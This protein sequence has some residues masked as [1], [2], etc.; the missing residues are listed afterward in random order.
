MRIT[1]ETH[2]GLLGFCQE[3]GQY[4]INRIPI[5]WILDIL[6]GLFTIIPGNHSGPFLDADQEWFRIR[7]AGIRFKRNFEYA[8]I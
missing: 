8:Q 7:P 6:E 3:N 2:D 5:R 1:T 4:T